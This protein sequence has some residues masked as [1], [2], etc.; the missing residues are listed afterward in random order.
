MPPKRRRSAKPSEA[1]AAAARLEAEAAAARE[2][3]AAAAGS[4]LGDDLFDELP[5]PPATPRPP[6]PDGAPDG[7][8]PARAVEEWSGRALDLDWTSSEPKAAPPRL[9]AGWAGQDTASLELEAEREENPRTSRLPEAPDLGPVMPPPPDPPETP[10]ADDGFGGWGDDEDLGGGATPTS[11]PAPEAEVDWSDMDLEDDTPAEPMSL[12]P[13]LLL[14][15]D[16]PYEPPTGPVPRDEVPPPPPAPEDEATGTA[17][18]AAGWPRP[19]AAWPPADTSPWAGEPSPAPEAAPPPP[20]PPKPPQAWPAPPPAPPQAAPE[21]PPGPVSAPQ[22]QPTEAPFAETGDLEE[23]D[24][25]HLLAEAFR[26]RATGV[27]EVR[28]ATGVRRIFVELG[29]PVG[30][31]SPHADEQL[32]EVAYRLGRI[33]REQ[34]RAL[35]GRE[36]TPRQAAVALVEEGVLKAA[37]LYETVRAQAEAA[38]FGAFA[39]SAGHWRWVEETC[40]DDDRVAHPEHPFALITEGIRRKF[41]LGRVHR[42]L[43]G[44]STVLAPAG[45][46]DLTLLGLSA[47]ERRLAEQVDGLKTAE[48]LVFLSGLGEE[49]TF[50]VLYALQTTGMAEVRFAGPMPEGRAADP[51]RQAVERQIDRTRITEK[52]NQALEA[53]YFEILGVAPEAT[54]Y[55]LK[56][57][58]ERQVRE[59][60]P[61]RY[62]DEAYRDLWGQLEEI[63]R[64]LDDAWDV[65]RD[66]GLRADYLEALARKRPA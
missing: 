47:R 19:D 23:T 18:D 11:V 9:G 40:E 13:D 16:A 8:P 59:F 57:A 65:L 38:L 63:R 22:P 66:E 37:E 26:A 3:E 20:R 64:A 27:L 6:P 58:Y 33:T 61:G 42:R 31:R 62:G 25:P 12:S 44:P 48:E 51:E 30:V 50:Q 4:S 53:D 17:P 10:A 49:P 41:P 24:V 34:A 35:R 2:I 45:G 55:E 32:G 14:D 21:P 28:D 39:V 5:P 36:L 15:T 43:G 1:E 46:V 29:R 52:F 7:R 54:S 60:Q 56:A